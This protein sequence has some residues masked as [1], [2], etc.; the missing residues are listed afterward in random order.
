MNECS[1]DFP[2]R[3]RQ[4]QVIQVQG[5]TDCDNGSEVA[6]V[7]NSRRTHNVYT[8]N[9]PVSPEPGNQAGVDT[10]QIAWDFMSRYSNNK[11]YIKQGAK[12]LCTE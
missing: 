3:M 5:F 1:G 4:M 7:T 10:P 6:L 8:I 11:S 9:D 12:F 2:A